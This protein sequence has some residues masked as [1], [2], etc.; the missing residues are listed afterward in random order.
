MTIVEADPYERDL[1]KL[2][3]RWSSLPEDISV[4][5]K[6]LI[7]NPSE[8]PPFS[9][10]LANTKVAFPVIKIKKIACRSLRGLGCATGLRLI[11]GLL[12][13]E[14]QIVFLELYHKADQTQPNRERISEW[15]RTM[16]KPID[17]SRRA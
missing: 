2:A 11:Y 5:K 9:V 3:K 15:G 4:L 16:A 1:R 8:R 17:L 10:R 13:E 6:V 12:K 14:E 7:V